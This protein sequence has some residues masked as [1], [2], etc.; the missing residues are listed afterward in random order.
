MKKKVRRMISAVL[1][2]VM[3]KTVINGIRILAV[4]S[5]GIMRKLSVG[6]C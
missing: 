6:M 3:Q 4:K 1:A 2:V 5:M